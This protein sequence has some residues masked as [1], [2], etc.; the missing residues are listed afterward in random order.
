MRNISYPIIRTPL[1]TGNEAHNFGSCLFGYSHY[2]FFGGSHLANSFSQLRIM[3]TGQTISTVCD[4]GWP[5]E[6]T[7]HFYLTVRGFSP[8]RGKLISAITTSKVACLLLCICVYHVCQVCMCDWIGAKNTPLEER[9]AWWLRRHSGSRSDANKFYFMSVSFTSRVN[10]SCIV[11]IQ[12]R[13]LIASRHNMAQ[14]A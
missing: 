7:F 11:S 13:S 4:C 9:R 1:P 6:N 5:D 3:F 8:H 14:L 10:S 2:S 12:W